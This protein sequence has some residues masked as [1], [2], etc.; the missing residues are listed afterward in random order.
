MPRY[1]VVAQGGEFGSGMIIHLE[2]CLLWEGWDSKTEFL[3]PIVGKLLLGT[4]FHRA[5]SVLRELSRAP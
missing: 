3:T 1:C 2:Q 5:K 4:L